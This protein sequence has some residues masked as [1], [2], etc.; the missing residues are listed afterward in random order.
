[1]FF[2]NFS[3]PGF[4]SW[5]ESFSDK[6]RADL[7]SK[8]KLKQDLDETLNALK[9]FNDSVTENLEK[10]FIAT[11]EYGDYFLLK[12]DSAGTR[13]GIIDSLISFSEQDTRYRIRLNDS[14]LNDMIDEDLWNLCVGENR[15]SFYLPEQIREAWRIY[16]DR[17][18]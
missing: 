1:M 9:S 4:I 8:F 15:F 11:N 5:S 13:S 10:G 7:Y 2:P 6:V 12:L 16:N 3:L 18:T 17:A 14:S